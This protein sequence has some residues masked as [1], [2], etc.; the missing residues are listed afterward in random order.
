MAYNVFISFDSKDTA[1]SRDLTKRLEKAG[2]T[3]TIAKDPKDSIEKLE[4]ADE[5]IFLIT[6]NAMKGK[7]ILYDMG[8]AT[9]LEKRLVPILVDMKPNQLPDIVKG[10]DFIKYDDLERYIGRLQR[11]ATKASKPPAKSQPKSGVTSKSVA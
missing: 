7:K 4:E 1:L 5:V 11:A 6:N 8:I 3:V 10:L 9:S 2:M